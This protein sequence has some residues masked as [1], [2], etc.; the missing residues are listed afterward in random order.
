MGTGARAPLILS[1]GTKERRVFNFTHRL[2]YPRGKTQNTHFIGCWMC[3]A[4]ELYILE[5]VCSSSWIRKPNRPAYSLVAVT[6]RVSQ[7]IKISRT[8]MRLQSVKSPS[9]YLESRHDIQK[10]YWT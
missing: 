1:L 4:A 9:I 8:V 7:L 5:K 6:T 10:I 3:H 2:L